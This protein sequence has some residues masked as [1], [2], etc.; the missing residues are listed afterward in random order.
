MDRVFLFE[1]ATCGAFAAL[2]P[3][4]TVE[5]MGMFRALEQGFENVESFIDSRIGN[6]GDFP[7]VRNY[8]ELFSDFL[9]KSDFFIIIAPESDGNL[10][11]LTKEAEKSGCTNLGSSPSAVEVAS[12]KLLTYRALQGLE[13]PRTEPFNGRATLDFPLIAKPRDGVSCDGV[14]LVRD[15]EELKNVPE[16]YILQEYVEGTPASATLL[17]GSDVRILSLNTQEIDNFNYTGARIPLEGKIETEEIIKSAERI[18]GLHGLV[19]IDFILSDKIN[20][21]EVNPR[22]TTPV[23]ALN[24]A[25]GFNISKLILDNYHHE[26]IPDFEAKKNVTLRKGAKRQNSFVSFGPYSIWIE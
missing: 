1:Y 18:K 10:H 21:I 23:I 8:E 15:E 6:F 7:K 5:G 3:S 22:P 24:E 4:I 11:S 14:T 19:G 17:V 9:Q 12:D 13:T 16:G 20:I 25:Y 26:K 2:E